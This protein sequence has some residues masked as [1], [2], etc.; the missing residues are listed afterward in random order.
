MQN[1]YRFATILGSDET[2]YYEDGKYVQFGE[3]KI[4]IV[5]EAHYGSDFN[6]YMKNEV[7]KHIKHQTYRMR[8]DFDTDLNIINMSNGL[9]DIR[10]N[11]LKPHTPN[12]LSMSQIPVV[13]DPKARPKQ[14]I[15][16]LPEFAYRRQIPKLISLMAYTFLRDNPE[17]YITTL[18]GVVQMVKVSFMLYCMDYMVKII[19]APFR[20]KP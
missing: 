16:F 13:Y 11:V 3:S 12:Y 4:N 15:K 5:L 9:Y 2:Y 10:N 20:L 8:S 14:F 18:Y 7:I 17:E 6:S 1:E 19:S